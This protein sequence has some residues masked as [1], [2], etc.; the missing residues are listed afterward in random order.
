YQHIGKA[1]L[2]IVDASSQYGATIVSCNISGGEGTNSNASSVITEVFEESGSHVYT[3]TVTDSRGRST[4]ETL[5][6][7]AISVSPI[8]IHSF[9]IQRYSAVIDDSGQTNYVASSDGD[10]VWVSLLA[11]HD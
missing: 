3:A 2:S 7:S 9:V 5:T 8:A 11:S 10:H 4:V 1:L 6:I